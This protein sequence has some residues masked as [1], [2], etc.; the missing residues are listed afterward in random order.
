MFS[1]LTDLEMRRTPLQALGFYLAYSIGLII[2]LA[3]LG[4]VVGTIASLL[5]GDVAMAV[6]KAMTDRELLQIVLCGVLAHQHGRNNHAHA[7]SIWFCSC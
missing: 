7:A 3:I 4:A 2:V 5:F 6:N 1:G